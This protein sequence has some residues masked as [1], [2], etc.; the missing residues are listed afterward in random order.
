MKS[1]ALDEA[2]L[3]TVAELS[4]GRYFRASDAGTLAGVFAEVDR[5]EAHET[6]VTRVLPAGALSLL[7]GLAGAAAPAFALLSSATLL[8]TA[9]SL[10]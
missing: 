2:T 7:A 6:P 1:Y 5:L 8:R 9:P 4:G 3:R 10:K